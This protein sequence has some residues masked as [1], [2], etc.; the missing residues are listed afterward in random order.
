MMPML[1]SASKLVLVAAAICAAALGCE[2]NQGTATPG[3]DPAAV[4]TNT[5]GTQ[6]GTRGTDP[7]GQPGAAMGGGQPAGPGQNTGM[8]GQGTG[9]MATADAGTTDGGVGQGVTGTG[10]PSGPSGKDNAPAGR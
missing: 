3:Q 7:A 4:T 1:N 5:P 8:T 6:K 9:S 10:Q 2:S